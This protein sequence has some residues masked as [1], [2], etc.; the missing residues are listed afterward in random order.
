MN[1]WDERYKENL[2]A[3]GN[4]PNIYLEKFLSSLDLK[5]KKILF[6]GERQGA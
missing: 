3:Y 2:G 6:P 1:F 4:S 5:G